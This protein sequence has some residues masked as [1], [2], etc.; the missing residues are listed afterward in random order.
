M[1]VDGV[2]KIAGP[3]GGTVPA[4]ATQSEKG[5]HRR[6][7]DGE[8]VYIGLFHCRPWHSLFRDDNFSTGDHIVF[9]RSSVYITHEGEETLVADPNV[10]VFY[11][12]GQHYQRDKL[13]ETGDFSEYF[14]FQ[15][16]ILLEVLRDYS[17]ATPPD[18]ENPFRL[19]HAPSDPQSYA[20]QRLVVQHLLSGTRPDPVFIEETGLLLLERILANALPRQQSQAKTAATRRAHR[21]LAHDARTLLATTFQESLT[22]AEMASTLTSSPFHLSRVFRQQTGE[23]IHQYRNQL[24]LRAGLEY[25]LD[26]DLDLS[27]LALELGYA[28]HSHF[29]QAFRRA[30]RL[31]PSALRENR[32]LA[33][34]SKNLTA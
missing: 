11:N 32:S 16:R 2:G 1:R 5:A 18:A 33:Q 7:F 15:P 30:F 24:R 13:S 10:V 4:G 31:T 3:A 17:L 28:N 9:P 21:E 34:L 19:T 14:G 12:Q 22:L 23:T 25:V 8:L 29:T 26:S 6:I 20:L 27:T